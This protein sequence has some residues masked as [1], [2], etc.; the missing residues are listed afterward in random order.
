[1]PM[2]N[3]VTL[4]TIPQNDDTGSKSP[5]SSGGAGGGDD[6]L[7]AIRKFGGVAGGL[8]SVSYNSCNLVYI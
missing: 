1:M 7:A 4:M 3:P 5:V 2:T 8:K 6:L